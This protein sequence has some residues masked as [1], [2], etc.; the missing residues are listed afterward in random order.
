MAHLHEGL[1]RLTVTA[2]L[3][4]GETVTL[5]ATV[6]AAKAQAVNSLMVRG[7][8]EMGAK[9]ATLTAKQMPIAKH[10]AATEMR[11]TVM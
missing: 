4:M 10:L 1:V 9:A 5:M 7:L 11:Q 6:E 8:A 2:Q 3:E